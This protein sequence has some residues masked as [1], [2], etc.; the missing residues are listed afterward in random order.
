MEVTVMGEDR[1][2]EA[3]VELADTLTE[4]F[5]VTDFLHV[6]VERCVEL[7]GVDAVG[8]LLA[9]QDGG[10]RLIATSDERVRL[11]E[12]FQ[13][14]N[15]EGPCL[16]AFAT[17]A[18]VGHPDLRTAGAR[19]PRFAPAAARS[20]YV[21]VD[22]VPMRLR[23]DVI[24]ALNLFRTRAGELSDTA[25]RTARALVDVATIGLLQE[26]SIRRQEVLTEQL[27]TALDS[28]VV[29]E[30]AKGFLAQRFGVDVDAAFGVLRRYARSHNLKLS[31]VA[32]A[33]TSGDGPR[34]L[35]DAI[36]PRPTYAPPNG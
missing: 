2:L 4:D 27:R 23:D 32:T 18:R 35:L 28:R 29:I 22:A 33:V 13:L 19:W 36:L 16:E 10:L 21:A 7:V 26:R 12:L 15:D 17:G 11:L 20:G 31:A 24:G 14:Q 5:D 30:Q 6:L 3:F 34:E 25:A 9:D 1:L 8:L